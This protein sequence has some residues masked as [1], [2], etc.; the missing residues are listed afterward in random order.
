MGREFRRIR[1]Q[2]ISGD[3]Y[4]LRLYTNLFLVNAALFMMMT[5][6]WGKCFNK[7]FQTIARQKRRSS[8]LHTEMVQSNPRT[9]RR[10]RPNS[11]QAFTAAATAASSCT[12]LECALVADC[13]KPLPFGF[14]RLCGRQPRILWAKEGGR[15]HHVASAF[16]KRAFKL[17]GKDRGTYIFG[18]AFLIE[19]SDLP[20]VI[21]HAKR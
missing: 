21:F 10:G 17:C 20:A 13:I 1:R 16:G 2:N 14:E 15:G 5:R 11:R 18:C 3:E 4:F 12:P 8:L 6:F 19:L 7:S 9:Y